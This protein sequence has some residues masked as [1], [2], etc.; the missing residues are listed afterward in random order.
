MM[1][2]LP[3]RRRPTELPRLDEL[4]YN[5]QCSITSPASIQ[6]ILKKIAIERQ[7][8]ELQPFYSIR[9]V[10]DHFR[11]PPARVSRVYRR[12]SSERL[13]RMVWGSKTLLEPAKSSRNSES[14]SIGVAIDLSRFL[15]SSDYRASILSLQLEIWN[16]EVNA[17]LLFFEAESVELV[18]VC[19][20]NHHPRMNTIVWPLPETLH[21]QTL[22]RLRDLG[23]RVICLS[24]NVIRG[25]PDCYT[26]SPRSTI[27]MIVRKKILKI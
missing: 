20:R 18:R 3:S 8:D 4:V 5:Q 23:L 24:N 11:V 7:N 1:E 19:T 13:L 26:I 12:L 27:R 15:K 16:H 17:H 14:R 9:A 6:A 10:A 25:I 2:V 21:N 22:L